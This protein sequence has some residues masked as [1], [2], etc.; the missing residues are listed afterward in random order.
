VLS[1][2]VLKSLIDNV[3]D[4]IVTIDHRGLIQSFNP[5]AECLFGYAEVYWVGNDTNT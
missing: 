5:A 2:T 4:G 3:V 1:K